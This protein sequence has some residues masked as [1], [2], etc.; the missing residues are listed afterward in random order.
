MPR[1]PLN[2]H[3]AEP[4]S[5]GSGTPSWSTDPGDRSVAIAVLSWAWAAVAVD[6]APSRSDAWTASRWLAAHP[7]DAS[8]A[9]RLAGQ[10]S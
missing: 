10:L 1:H 7:S 2:H 9:R 3:P 8:L 6:A 4:V 5:A